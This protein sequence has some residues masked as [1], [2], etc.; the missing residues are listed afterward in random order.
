[1][2]KAETV[3]VAVGELALGVNLAVPGPVTIVQV[4]IPTLGTALK[5]KFVSHSTPPAPPFAT[6]TV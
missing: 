3:T 2:P 1:M 6:G 4:P 5:T